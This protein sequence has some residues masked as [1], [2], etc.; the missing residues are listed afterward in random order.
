MFSV[1]LV[2]IEQTGHYSLM[3]E[4]LSPR[5]L[6]AAIGVSESSL[7]RWVDSGQLH[8]ARTIGGHR[9]I[10]RTEA[11]RFIRST[12]TPVVRPEILGLSGLDLELRGT[13]GGDTV[14]QLL[15]A[16]RDDDR[17]TAHSVLVSAFLAGE[18]L[19]ELFDG[20]VRA[21]MTHIG[22]LW[23]EDPTGIIVEHRAVDT[24]VQAIN[25][26]RGMLPAPPAGAPLAVGGAPATDPYLLPTLMVATVVADAGYRDVNLGADVPA[27][28]LR[29]AVERYRPRI[30]WLAATA[31]I[32]PDALRAYCATVAASEHMAGAALIVGGRS[33]AAAALLGLPRVHVLE[34]MTAMA[35]FARTLTAAE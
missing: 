15:E 26:L 6:A 22:A 8:A 3:Q 35:T 2:G 25:L 33:A 28:T 30:V 9:R 13:R 31:P 19:A 23:I 7:K 12:G 10:A 16:L 27:D 24:C 4:F 14:Q 32:A 18:P 17:V 21:A 34:S 20:A 1:H 5:D 11:L 29:E